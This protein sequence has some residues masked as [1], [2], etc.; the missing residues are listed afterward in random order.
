MQGFSTWQAPGGKYRP[1]DDLEVVR[2][3]RP[4]SLADAEGSPYI[5]AVEFHSTLATKGCASERNASNKFLENLCPHLKPGAEKKYEGTSTTWAELAKQ[6]F[7]KVCDT[8]DFL[9]I[10]KELR[11]YGV[12]RLQEELGEYVEDGMLTTQNPFVKIVE[13]IDVD[14]RVKLDIQR[15]QPWLGPYAEEF[16]IMVN[17]SERRTE[18]AVATG[19]GSVFKARETKGHLKNTGGMSERHEFLLMK[20]RHWQWFNVL[21]AGLVKGGATLE[22]AF[23][24]ISRM[25][26]AAM[27]YTR[28]S[29]AASLLGGGMA[30]SENI[31]L[32]FHCYPH[33][34]LKSLHLHIVDL[35]KV[36]PA[37]EALKSKRLSVD[38]V[39]SALRAELDFEKSVEAEA[40]ITVEFQNVLQ[41]A[42]FHT[43]RFYREKSREVM[44]QDHRERQRRNNLYTI[45]PRPWRRV[46]DPMARL[47]QKRRE[48]P[49]GLR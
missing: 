45:T 16:Q 49:T 6:N 46:I 42:D 20:D 18:K 36:G 37:F 17:K 41:T 29:A 21:T 27:H 11:L 25:K 44:T 14:L 1:P 4:A 19:R 43:K 33:V 12:D 10:R 13:G 38:D 31:R 5:S 47:K 2:L 8:Q 7:P 22:E 34:G 48:S 28:A 35:D 40:M 3:A 23:A 26:D 24:T 9:A 39:L 32:Y 30:W 15:R